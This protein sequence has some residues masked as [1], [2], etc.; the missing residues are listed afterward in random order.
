MCSGI[1]CSPGRDSEPWM[2][3]RLDPPTP[4]AQ[5]GWGPVSGT[6]ELLQFFM[7]CAG[8]HSLWSMP[9]K[10]EGGPGK[11]RDRSSCS[12]APDPQKGRWEGRTGERS[13]SHLGAEGS[14]PLHDLGACALRMRLDP[15]GSVSGEAFVSAV[16]WPVSS[17][18]VKKTE[19]E[20][21]CVRPESRD[22]V[23]SMSGLQPLLVPCAPFTAVMG[24][25]PHTC[26]VHALVCAHLHL[27]TCTC[28]HALPPPRA[29]SLPGLP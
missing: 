12:E 29:W 21:R 27:H 4:P 1:L 10:A 26:T 8:T 28:V 6:A 5:Q 7:H 17:Q 22:V 3:A 9:R 14:L 18:E 24:S 23:I 15:A 20:R 11:G 16:V 2:P 25:S 19:A 13:L